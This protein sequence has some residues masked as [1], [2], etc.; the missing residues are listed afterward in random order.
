M[1]I[2][3]GTHLDQETERQVSSEEAEQFKLENQINYFLE[4]SAQLNTNI[5]LAF[6]ESVRIIKS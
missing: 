1:K 4:T 2:L 6:Q 5:E 3:I